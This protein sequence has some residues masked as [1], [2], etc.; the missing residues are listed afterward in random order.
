MGLKISH[1]KIQHAL[2]DLQNIGIRIILTS[3]DNVSV[4]IKMAGDLGT[5][6]D[7]NNRQTEGDQRLREILMKNNE[8]EKNELMKSITFMGKATSDDKL[9]LVK[10]LKAKG[11]T[12]AFIG[13]LT[14]GDV[15]T[16]IEAD[17]G[18]IQENRSTKECKLVSDL[19]YEDVTSLNHTLKYGR[20]NYLNIKKFYQLQLTALISGLLIT[21]ICTM[22]SGKSPITSF[23][24]TWV[25][26]ITCLLG[27]LMMV[28]ELN[29]E[30]VQNV[31]GGSDRNQA[32]ITRDIVKKIVIHVLCQASV[33]LIIEYLGHKIVPQMKEDVRDTMIFNTYILC[34]I[35]NLLGAISVGLV[36][37]RA[38]VFQVAVQI[39]WVL[40]FVVGVLAV[41]VVVI[42]LHGTIVNGVKLSALQWIICFLFALALGWASYIFLHFAIH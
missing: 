22:V 12:V 7:P 28:M 1:E 14:S 2:K 34:Q 15:P 30:E 11:E 38:A 5:R 20:S 35:A 31:V 40:I 21:L 17:I 8:R 36:T 16:L 9:V 10:E 37:N 18:I 3:K 23:H 27:G 4:I 6:C 33:F 24:L 32:L 13:G 29:D 25:T 26:L 19:R 42:E 39:L 41:Q